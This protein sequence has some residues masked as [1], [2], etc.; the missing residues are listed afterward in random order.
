MQYDAFSASNGRTMTL[1]QL[2]HLIALADTG[3]FSRAAERVFLT[4]PA[5]SRSIQSLEDELGATLFDRIGRRA[6][7]T[8]MGRDILERA[9]L[10]VLDAQ[11]LQDRARATALGRM[12]KLRVGMGSG[13][14]ALLMTQLLLQVAATRPQWRVEVARGATEL[15]AQRLRAG[16]LDALVV[17]LR[18]LPAD[19]GLQIELEREL[20][21]AFMVR[22]GHPLARRRR[23]RFEELRAYPMAGIP[24]S[25]EVASALVTLY[26]SA[27]HPEQALSV[28]GEDIVSLVEV[29]QRSDAVLLSIRAAAPDLVELPLDPPMTVSARLGL[30][31]LARRTAPAS[32]EVLRELAARLMVDPRPDRTG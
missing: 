14:A 9:R 2:R 11:D 21:G 6:E 31:T 15:L 1:V 25:A 4:Q 3:S 7:L 22:R 27:A 5:L 8:P 32:L 24:L 20:R 23:L 17:D 10:L 18:S 26:G 19:D 12:G 13:P 30:V 28:R 29:V 16:T